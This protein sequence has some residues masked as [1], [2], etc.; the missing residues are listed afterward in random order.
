MPINLS[1]LQNITP[2]QLDTSIFGNSSAETL[3]NI[4]DN[5]NTTSD[6]W[7]GLIIMSV[8][9]LFLVYEFFRVDGD[10]RMDM[11]RTMI[12]ASGWTFV[13]GTVLILSSII[14]TFEPIVWYGIV[15]TIFGISSMALK[16]KNL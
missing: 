9:F 1:K 14:T 12:K 3:N 4:I 15:F 8:L 10:F 7:L 16:R 13:F 11:V 6:G 5:A 2:F